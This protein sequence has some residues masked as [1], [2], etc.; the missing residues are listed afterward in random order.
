MRL[1]VPILLCLSANAF[2]DEVIEVVGTAP[3][4]A[5]TTVDA[6]QL[7]RAEHDDIHKVLATVAGVYV[8]GE[9]GYG[10]R[11][12]IGMRGAA[13]ERSAKVTLMED[14]VL[15]APAPYSAPAAYYFP[16]VTRMEK[17]EVTKGPAAIL[18]G[19]ATVGGAVDLVGA[20]IPAEREG[21]VDAALGSDTYGKLHG[22]FAEVQ[23]RWAVMGEA[24]ALTTDGF[25]RIDGGGDS[26]FTK[27]DA[28]LTARWQSDF[29]SRVFHRVT[30]R[31]GWSDEVS[32]ETY[33]G[34]SVA[35]F[36]AMSQRRYVSTQL[37]QMNWD[38]WR[39][40]V[41]HRVE[42][43]TDTR[44]ETTAYH[45][46]F[47]RAW[48]KVDG[49]VGDRDIAGILA[50]PTAGSNAIYY[51]VLTGVA[52]SSSPEDELIR[53]IND[54]AFVSQGVQ[55]F[56]TAERHLGDT[57]HQ[58]DAGVRLHRDRAHRRRYEDVY[59]MSSGALVRTE[60]PRALALDSIATTMAL[61]L[62][63]QDQVR[64]RRF[65]LTAG[66]RVEVIHF[67]FDDQLGGMQGAGT[68][69]VPIPGGGVQWHAT[70]DVT[71]LAGV[72]RGF[73]PSAPSAASDTSPESSINYEAGARWHSAR[74]AADVI[75]FVS[76]YSN[77]KGTCTLSAGCDPNHLDDEYD[78]GRVLV[79]GLEAQ[80]GLDLDLGDGVRLPIT[81]AYTYTRSRFETAFMSDFAGWGEVAI[82][83]ELPYQP[84]HQLSIGATAAAPRWEIGALASWHGA[85]RDVPGQ[86]AIVDDEHIDAL[87]T[88]D[89]T[90]HLRFARAAELYLTCDNVLDAQVIVSRR[91]Y[92]VR[93]NAPRLF[94]LGYKARF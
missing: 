76:D 5:E 65:E 21:Y 20:S 55:S 52:D 84:R 54:R 48:G 19:P 59:R 7:E 63:A 37:D 93:P 14:G 3:P 70:E 74:V 18:Y 15:I 40:R 57:F 73:V 9:D 92:G 23:E 87:F 88:L 85:S 94:T 66:T 72:H 62:H 60:R 47:H 42:L 68:Y 24:L 51:A 91:P 44:I 43:G 1:S 25:K 50:D 26:G 82:G 28:Q 31:A 8:R 35:D 58:L 27:H 80:L 29:T 10:L 64:W 71:L 6:E 79:G 49:F 17:V 89:T 67:D 78:G 12:N 46:D 32:N 13:A 75:G 53:G 16:L 2:A 30:A 61:A 34:L 22:R 81:G 69:A 4:G 56:L 90:M 77:L 11:P 36:E 83:D 33:T 41:D 39:G 86:G 45:H 38:H